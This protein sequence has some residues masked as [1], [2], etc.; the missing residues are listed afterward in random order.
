[1]PYYVFRLSPDQQPELI[2]SYAKFQEAMKAARELRKTEGP[3]ATKTVRMA[4]G[5]NEKDARR[6]LA[7]KRKPSTPL[8]EWEA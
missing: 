5:E 4:F 6:L 7:E 8:E 3:G 1:M 2:D